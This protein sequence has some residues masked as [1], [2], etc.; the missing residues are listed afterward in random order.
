MH[1][2]VS[3]IS[4]T[5]TCRSPM[6][7]LVAREHLLRAGLHD[8]VRITSAGT[9]LWQAGEPADRRAVAVLTAAGYPTGHVATPLG[10]DHLNANL[11]VAMDCGH[12][13]TLRRLVADTAAVRLLRTFDP[14]VGEDLGIPD[15]FYGGPEGF[16]EVLC[17]IESA[18]PGVLTWL[19]SKLKTE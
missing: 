19:E 17:M 14:E 2:H 4:S 18:M 1:V 9:G 13:R 8:R 3:F 7:A 12:I 5:N 10:P 6:A 11:L 15:P 16:A